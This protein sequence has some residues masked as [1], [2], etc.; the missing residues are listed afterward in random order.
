MLRISSKVQVDAVKTIHVQYDDE[1]LLSNARKEYASMNSISL[2]HGQPPRLC[3]RRAGA[4]DFLPLHQ[5]CLAT[6]EHVSVRKYFQDFRNKSLGLQL[7]RPLKLTLSISCSRLY[8]EETEFR[9]AAKLPES[10][11]NG[12]LFVKK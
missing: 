8:I 4:S 7:I 3:V 11:S 9:V 10:L 5:P 1:R 6:D 2:A 12:E